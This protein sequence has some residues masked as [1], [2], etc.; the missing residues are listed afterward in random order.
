MYSKTHILL[1]CLCLMII[2]T[3]GQLSSKPGFCPLKNTIDKCTPRCVSDYQCSSNQKCCPNKC[4][5][6]SC[7]S[8]NAVNTGNGYKGSPNSG[9]VICAGVTC[10]AQEKCQFDRNTKR[11]KCVR[12]VGVV[13]NASNNLNTELEK[14]DHWEENPVVVV[15]DKPVNT[16]QSK[17]EQ[18]RQQVTKSTEPPVEEQQPNFFEDMT[19]KITRQTK[20]LIKD[21]KI[22][23]VSHNPT[24]FAVAIDPIPTNELKEWEDNAISWEEETSEEIG[25]PTK[26]LREYKRRERE[27]RL[28]E[29]QQKRL[30]R[31]ARPQPLGAKINS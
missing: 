13:P 8:S 24:K 17:I 27:Q 4:G 19:P 21:K 7:T 10:R 20:L 30:E 29:Q 9:A 12:A 26:A 5:S 14:W 15:P 18:Y 1:F 25:D 2:V 28:F 3:A 22:E 31:N 16:V 23:N 11:E 6:T